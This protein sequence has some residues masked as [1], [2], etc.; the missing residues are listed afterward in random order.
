MY[1]ELGH[2]DRAQHPGVRIAPPTNVGT[3]LDP[4]SHDLPGNRPDAPIST[5]RWDASELSATLLADADAFTSAE[6]FAQDPTQGHLVGPSRGRK[7]RR[8]VPADADTLTSAEEV[9]Q[10]LPQDYP[11]GPLGE[12]RSR[13]AHTRIAPDPSHDTLAESCRGSEPR[14]A[15]VPTDD[16]P[17][18]RDGGQH[19]RMDRQSPNPHSVL[20]LWSQCESLDPDPA[21]TTPL[22][23][24]GKASSL[25]QW[26]RKRVSSIIKK[27]PPNPR[28]PSAP[29][30]PGHGIDPLPIADDRPPDPPSSQLTR[31]PHRNLPEPEGP[32]NPTAYGYIQR[33]STIDTLFLASARVHTH[34]ERK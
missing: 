18:G 22:E 13:H 4:E 25:L 7:P 20:P 8:A 17:V 26:G 23:R 30:F 2:F 16:F 6:D 21:N 14:L 10:D 32:E 3:T 24:S 1:T 28:L 5:D 27:N 19:P 29:P 34:P 15:P 33:A 9:A 31:T 12:A 11:E